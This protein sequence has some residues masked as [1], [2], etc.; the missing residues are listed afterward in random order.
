MEGRAA[1]GNSG[2]SFHAGPMGRATF[3]APAF[4]E[5]D[6]SLDKRAWVSAG[7]G[8]QKLVFEP[9]ISGVYDLYAFC[10]S[11]DPVSRAL[12]LCDGAVVARGSG[13]GHLLS[14][15]LAAGKRYVLE[16]QL[17]W[18][19]TLEWMRH[20]A[21]RSLLL[22]EVLDSDVT[23]GV[24]SAAGKR[25]VVCLYRP[26]RPHGDLSFGGSET[27]ERF[28]ARGNL[29]RDGHPA[30]AIPIPGRSGVS[31]S[32]RGSGE[33]VLSAGLRR[34]HGSWKIPGAEKELSRAGPGTVGDFSPG[35]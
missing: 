29:R 10:G 14:A 7:S 30:G 5:S 35:T 27:G 25:P 18:D 26:E 19:C 31:V 3:R 2:A 20:V 8:S 9:K 16:I 6:F 13:G 1:A 22:P 23:Q 4:A 28:P 15:S 17:R 34:G 32:G 12:L 21:G 33:D 11:G 24:D